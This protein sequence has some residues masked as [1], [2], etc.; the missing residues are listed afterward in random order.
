MTLTLEPTDQRPATATASAQRLRI[1]TA[2][3]RVSLRWLGVRKTLTP[4]QKSQAAETFDAEGDY[5]SARKKLLDTK[6]PAYKEVTAVRGRVIAYWKG[7]SLPF[8]EPGT[9]LIRQDQIEPFDQ[10]MGDFREQLD[11]AVAKLDDHYGELKT[12]ARR[13]LGSLYNAD[14]YPPALRGLFGISW[15]FPSVEPPDYL[16]QLNPVIYE[17]ERARVAARFEEAVTLAEQ[18]F[19]GELAQL[20]S[21]LSERLSGTADGTKKVFRDTVV[22]NLTEFFDRFR[23][24]NVRSNAQLDD[25][26]GQAQ[27][28]V[29]GVEPRELRDNDALRQHIATQLAGVQSVL[30]GMM[31]D[32][33]RRAIIRSRAREGGEA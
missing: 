15:E 29:R 6:H 24:L 13:R 21:H 1:T 25:L 26:V 30:D 32:R 27:R 14:D 17:Q 19:I 7:V 28:I 11:D 8:P 9:R 2:A 23:Q 18:A 12:A 10:Q 16:L 5:L 20:V 22:S 3:V 31:V 4:E 33:P